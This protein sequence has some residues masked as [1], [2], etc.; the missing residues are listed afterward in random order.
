M[1]DGKLHPLI[2]VHTDI[3]CSGIGFDIVVIQYSGSTARLKICHPW[4]LKS[5]SKGKR[6]EI[7]VL[8]H[9][10]IIRDGALQLLR[11]R[12]D[13]NQKSGG[14]RIWRNPVTIS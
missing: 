4:I 8:E 2:V 1:G 7:I 13:L 12:E 6:T 10:H 14:L 9:E 11:Y 3:G 5:E